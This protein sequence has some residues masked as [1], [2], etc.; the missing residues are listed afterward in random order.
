VHLLKGRLRVAWIGIAEAEDLRRRRR[1]VVDGDVVGREGG[2]V[3]VAGECVRSSGSGEVVV[4]DSEN[5]EGGRHISWIFLSEGMGIFVFS[6]KR[7][8]RNRERY[9]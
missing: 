7:F 5:V 9:Q 6:V 1:H 4:V 3:T 8:E 2:E